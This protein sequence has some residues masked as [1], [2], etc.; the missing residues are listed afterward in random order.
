MTWVSGMSR[1]C[2][3]TGRPAGQT[4]P[5][6]RPSRSFPSHAD[7]ASGRAEG[8]P[9]STSLKIDRLV[10]LA[11]AD[12]GRAEA[13]LVRSPQLAIKSYTTPISEEV[14]VSATQTHLV[15]SRRIAAYGVAL[16]L[17]PIEEW[18]KEVAPLSGDPVW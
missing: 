16:A 15:E 9:T 4:A 3:G 2:A 6:R 10:E 18:L 7:L 5:G 13:I 17:W 12:P 11:L 1:E 14:R 8:L